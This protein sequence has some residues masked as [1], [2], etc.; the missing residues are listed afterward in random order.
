MLIVMGALAGLL[1]VALSAAA[2]HG[3][4]SGPNLETAS[5]FLLIHAPVLLVIVTLAGTGSINPALGRVAGWVMVLGLALF[6]GDLVMR[7]LRD[8]ALFPRAAPIGGFLLMSG[9]GFTAIAALL[10]ALR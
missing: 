6:C 8:A 10:R 7:A 5:R 4:A 9:W 1:G 2:A 3:P